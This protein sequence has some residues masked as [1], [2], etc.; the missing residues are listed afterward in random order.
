MRLSLNVVGNIARR[1]AADYRDVVEID[2]IAAAPGD[3]N[4]VELLIT[5]RPSSSSSKHVTVAATR[6]DPETFEADL[7][8][9]LTRA[10]GAHVN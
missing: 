3:S 1:V 5:I 10:L 2:G 6:S 4:V 8:R 9:R 7:R